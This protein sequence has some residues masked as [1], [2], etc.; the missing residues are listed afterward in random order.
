MFCGRS[1]AGA[2]V[3]RLGLEQLESEEGRVEAEVEIETEA[4]AALAGSAWLMVE[5]RS[6]AL[7]G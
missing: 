3:L 5:V 7:E 6:T 2:L 4:C 1:P